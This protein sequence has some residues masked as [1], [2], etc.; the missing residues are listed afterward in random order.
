VVAEVDRVPNGYRDTQ[1]AVTLTEGRRALWVTDR[2][3]AEYARRVRRL[4]WAELGIAVFLSGFG[5]VFTWVTIGI[6]GS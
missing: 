5:G 6:A 3:R 4:G 1:P 2:D